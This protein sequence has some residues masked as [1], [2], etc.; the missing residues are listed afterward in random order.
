MIT[1]IYIIRIIGHRSSPMKAITEVK[2][3]VNMND[4][5][6]LEKD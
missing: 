6:F 3:E 5:H 4:R 1:I 2:F